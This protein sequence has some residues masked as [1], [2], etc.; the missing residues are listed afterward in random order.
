MRLHTT[1]SRTCRGLASA[2][3]SGPCDQAGHFGLEVALGLVDA[4]AGPRIGVAEA[5]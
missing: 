5:G 3:P 1:C 2:F 4:G